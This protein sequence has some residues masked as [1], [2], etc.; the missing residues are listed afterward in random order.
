M[1]VDH[2]V[3][4]ENARRRRQRFWATVVAVIVAVALVALGGG[5][6]LR[7]RYDNVPLKELLGLDAPEA[8]PGEGALPPLIRQKHAQQLTD[9]VEGA[10]L[11]RYRV[12]DQIVRFG[13][14]SR[15]PAGLEAHNF[16][17]RMTDGGYVPA[18]VPADGSIQGALT[19]YRPPSGD[20][21]L[22][23][24]TSRGIKSAFMYGYF[25]LRKMP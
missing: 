7:H 22:I 11:H 12:V 17:M 14:I 1:P 24:Y 5:R 25:D 3:L 21:R 2:T 20:N 19:V 23:A 16:W 8:E 10:F 9:E 15:D 4:I 6:Y 18:Q 13:G